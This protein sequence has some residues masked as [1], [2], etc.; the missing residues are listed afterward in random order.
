R[1]FRILPYTVRGMAGESLQQLQQLWRM[2]LE[3]AQREFQEAVVISAEAIKAFKESFWS[4]TPDG[5]ESLR[6]AL[7]KERFARQKY[8]AILRTFS[9]LIVHGEIPAEPEDG[10]FWPD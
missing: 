8:M 5:G 7:R 9:R 10:K 1:Q 3:E 2:R 4:P 6:K